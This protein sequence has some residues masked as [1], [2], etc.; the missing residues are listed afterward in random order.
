M[1]KKYPD[2]I[3]PKD[4]KTVLFI[5]ENIQSSMHYYFNFHPKYKKTYKRYLLKHF[6]IKIEDTWHYRKCWKGYLKSL[7][8]NK[9]VMFIYGKYIRYLKGLIN[10]F[11]QMEKDGLLKAI[12]T[13]KYTDA[14]MLYFKSDL[15][16][17]EKL[18]KEKIN[19]K[20][21]RLIKKY[22]ITKR[23]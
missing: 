20:I 21:N 13:V 22:N 4:E 7:I 23:R 9:Y 5:N 14:I 8:K 12:D 16:Q 1:Q 18:S 15:Y 11:K 3:K 19:E 10:I 17:G 2:G 6:N